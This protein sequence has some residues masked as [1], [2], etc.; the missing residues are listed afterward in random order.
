MVWYCWYDARAALW[1]AS[2]ADACAKS[3]LVSYSTLGAAAGKKPA[4][5]PHASRR[6]AALAVN[7]SSDS[8]RA[9]AGERIAQIAAEGVESR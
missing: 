2:A 4:E 7:T 3:L 6:D 1:H 9:T 5:V 8:I